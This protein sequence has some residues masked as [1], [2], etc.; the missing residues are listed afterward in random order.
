VDVVICFAFE[1]LE[2][3]GTYSELIHVL[4]EVT[5]VIAHGRS[6]TLSWIDNTFEAALQ[7]PVQ[8]VKG[9]ELNPVQE[10]F[11][12][13]YVMVDPSKTDLGLGGDAPHRG[14]VVAHLGKD[15]CRRIQKMK[16]LA[17]EAGGPFV[18]GIEC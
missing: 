11:F 10:L 12:T 2:L 3:S 4:A 7:A 6:E 16:P 18:W 17:I 13:G 8:R 15:P 5:D 9:V 14:P 1:G